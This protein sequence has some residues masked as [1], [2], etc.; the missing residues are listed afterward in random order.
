M[1]ASKI[2]LT[3][4][5]SGK[6]F[7]IHDFLAGISKILKSNSSIGWLACD[8]SG[9]VSIKKQIFNC[10][11]NALCDFTYTTFPRGL[12]YEEYTCRPPDKRLVRYMP[13]LY[14]HMMSFVPK[15]D[16]VL[17]VEDDIVP[18]DDNPVP[19]MLRGFDEGTAAVVGV[20]FI[21]RFTK[22]FGSLQGSLKAVKPEGYSVIK[23]TAFGLIMMKYEY[24][25]MQFESYD[26]KRPFDGI[27]GE[28]VESCGKV[29][30]ISWKT[31]AK[32]YFKTCDGKVGYV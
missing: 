1:K 8:T 28:K 15:C 16:F 3:T 2:I 4:A 23:R 19:D 21:R 5:I 7:V 25:Q 12:K 32:H 11:E 20:T 18:Y 6:E 27:F 10:A 24:S 14:N 26:Y 29:I 13:I 22:A 17:N 9:H 31:N 30:K